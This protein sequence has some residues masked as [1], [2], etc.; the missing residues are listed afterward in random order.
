MLKNDWELH[1]ICL[2]VRDWNDTLDYYQSARMGVNV[3]PQVMY[4]DYRNGG[5]AEFY[6]NDKL[7]RTNGGSGPGKPL[8]V[9]SK[10]ERRKEEEKRKRYKFMDK[11]CQVGDLLLEIGQNRSIPLE[12]I[13]HLCFN[14]PD[15]NAETD[16]LLEKGCKLMSCITQSDIILENHIDTRK[17]GNVDISFRPPVLQH[18]QA[19]IDHV[20][21]HPNLKDWKFHGIGIG[22]R[23]L[24]KAVEYWE[25]LDIIDFQSETE[26]DSNSL[27]PINVSSESMESNFKARVRVGQV[28]SVAFEFIQPL[29]G[30]SIYHESLDSRGEGVAD[31]AFKVADL[32]K[33]AATMIYRGMPVVFNGKPKN[34]P[35]FACFDARENN[36]NIL[37]KLI[38]RD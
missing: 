35:A 5:P 31:I 2:V 11:D 34:G 12:G 13:T 37:V 26:I 28:G 8:K 4:L 19:W 6:S 9:E 3:G 32:E 1:H 38:Q 15:I 24:D 30:A 10:R 29:E 18:E 20:R 23:D 22:I 36:G 7:P 33:E 27:A 21:S 16:K 25:M 14:V 17:Y